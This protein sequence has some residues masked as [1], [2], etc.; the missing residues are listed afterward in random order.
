MTPMTNEFSR[1][2]APTLAEYFGDDDWYKFTEELDA[3]RV[4]DILS[5][6]HAPSNSA[7][8]TSTK[9]LESAC[10]DFMA[11]NGTALFAALDRLKAN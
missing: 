8:A 11:E 5:T 4:A 10:A 6:E 3:D 1:T 2:A 9:T 7:H